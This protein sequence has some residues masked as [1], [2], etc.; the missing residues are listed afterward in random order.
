[1]RIV[2]VVALTIG[3]LSPAYA[4]PRPISVP[5]ENT[6]GSL[7]ARGPSKSP[8]P[9]DVGLHISY[10]GFSAKKA[11]EEDSDTA[12]DTVQGYLNTIYEKR[13]I[14]F[15]GSTFYF[16]QDNKG[17]VRFTV[18]DPV[19]QRIESLGIR[20][21]WSSLAVQVMGKLGWIRVG[22]YSALLVFSFILLALSCARINYTLHIPRGDPLNGGRDFYD[23]V[24]PELIFTTL[25][26]MSWSGLMLFVFFDNALKLRFL[27]L[28]GDELIGLAIL[29]I[30]WIGGAGAASSLWGDLSFCQQFEACRI[31]SALEAFAWLGIPFLFYSRACNSYRIL[32]FTSRW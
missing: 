7:Q 2:Y 27:R 21:F 28:Y 24:I 11:S 17:T 13:Q 18:M 5:I 3:L 32:V 26:T 16:F 9:K 19:G 1:M 29:W 8:Q 22:L 20:F 14:S 10:T 6:V 15:A 12:A 25:V 30:F 31:L 23:P 4:V